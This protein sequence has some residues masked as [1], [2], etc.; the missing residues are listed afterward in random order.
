[1]K[2]NWILSIEKSY[3]E[4]VKEKLLKLKIIILH[5]LLEIGVFTIQCSKE[6][7]SKVKKIPGILSI[8]K[9]GEMSV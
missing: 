4:I 3:E 6:E 8:E 5:E 2:E 7:I 9:E 1:M